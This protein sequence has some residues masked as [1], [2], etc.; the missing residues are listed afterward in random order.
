M[1]YF[2]R[3]FWVLLPLLL[4]QPVFG[5][6]GYTIIV[7]GGWTHPIDSGN[8]ISGAGSNLLNTYQSDTRATTLSVIGG[9]KN[10]AWQVYIE[11]SEMNW[12]VGFQLAVKRTGAGDGKEG[13]TVRGGLSFQ[14]VNSAKT[15]FLTG[16]GDVHSIPVQYQLSGVSLGTSP[17]HYNTGVIFTVVP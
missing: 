3:I 5:A 1:A 16:T 7:M 9:N 6:H 14:N 17:N 15:L 12:P 8:L 2:K 11:C 13:I 10:Q 4:M